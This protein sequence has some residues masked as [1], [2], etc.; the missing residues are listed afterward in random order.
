M[1]W[2]E[3]EV[4]SAK[5]HRAEEQQVKNLMNE[6]E[7]LARYRLNCF[8]AGQAMA[9]MVRMILEAGPRSGFLTPEQKLKSIEKAVKEYKEIVN[10]EIEDHCIRFPDSV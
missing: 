5:E 7:S 1:G 2:I 4:P 6:Q 9:G 3:R 8:T 10:A